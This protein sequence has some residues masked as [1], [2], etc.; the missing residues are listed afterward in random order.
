MPHLPHMQALFFCSVHNVARIF[1]RLTRNLQY[2][3]S[4]TRLSSVS[5]QAILVQFKRTKS[6]I[7]FQFRC[8]SEPCVHQVVNLFLS[9]T[10]SILD[11]PYVSVFW[12]HLRFT[13]KTQNFSAQHQQ[14]F[15]EKTSVAFHPDQECIICKTGPRN[16]PN[17]V[18]D[19]LSAFGCSLREH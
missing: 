14:H 5:R 3:S 6:N 12:V 11:H 17:W 13:Q 8:K 9:R 18:F 15:T 10:Q 16:I 19:K 4:S 2:V 1:I 7:S